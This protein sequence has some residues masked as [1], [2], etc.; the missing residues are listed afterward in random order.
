MSLCDIQ[1]VESEFSINNIHAIVATD[2]TAAAGVMV[3]G[4]SFKHQSL[5]THLLTAASC[6]V[7]CSM[8]WDLLE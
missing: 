5:L 8:Y 1:I 6:M 4:T 2:Q 3:W 7:N